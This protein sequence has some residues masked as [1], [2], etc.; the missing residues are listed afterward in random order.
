MGCCGDCG[1]GYSCCCC[2][3]CGTGV[4]QAA[5]PQANF[6]E[7]V[8]PCHVWPHPL[9][10]HGGEGHVTRARPLVHRRRLGA[11]RS[12]FPGVP[13]LA[14]TATANKQVGGGGDSPRQA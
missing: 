12:E 3:C 4:S 2:C 5:L 8:G 11:L 6:V 7:V 10:G 1:G 9:Q 13:L 14:L